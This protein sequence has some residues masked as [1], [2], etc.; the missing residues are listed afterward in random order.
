MGD[1][2]WEAMKGGEVADKTTALDWI[3]CSVTDADVVPYAAC[4]CAR[5]RFHF[6][7]PV[8]NSIAQR[9]RTSNEREHTNRSLTHMHGHWRVS[10]DKN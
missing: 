6:S 10:A 3:K 8:S 4:L 1:H 2:D 7:N 9:A 5:I